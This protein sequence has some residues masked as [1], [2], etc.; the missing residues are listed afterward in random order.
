MTKPDWSPRARRRARIDRRRRFA[1]LGLLALAAAAS[2]VAVVP[3][4]TTALA[5]LT[6]DLIRY[7]TPI[8]WFD[9]HVAVASVWCAVAAVPLW[10]VS[11]RFRSRPRERAGWGAM[12]TAERA[13]LI[14]SLTAVVALV[15]AGMSLQATRDQ[16][17]LAA[18]G[19]LSDRYAK[20]VEQLAS[21]RVEVRISGALSLERIAL[22]SADLDSDEGRDAFDLLAAFLRTKAPRPATGPCEP[23]GDTRV[24]AEVLARMSARRGGAD[25]DLRGACLRGTEWDGAELDGV[26]LREA[27]LGGARLVGARLVEAKLAGA[28]LTGA[29]LRRASLANADLTGADLRHTDLSDAV[30]TGADLGGARLEH[31]K[32]PPNAPPH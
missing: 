17:R 6:A 29:D 12:S 16:V 23:S 20:A 26:D 28:D 13:S 25:V 7:M 11:R 3:A 4:L 10:L 1:R 22:D 31:A 21:D 8:P 5:L 18:K 15:F 14:T 32:L 24:V 9:H 2:L 30:L 19:Q 27:D